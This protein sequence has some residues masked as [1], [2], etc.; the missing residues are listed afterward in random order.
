MQRKHSGK[1]GRR[2]RKRQKASIGRGCKH[3]GVCRFCI[4]GSEFETG[5]GCLLRRLRAST[6]SKGS[7]GAWGP[8]ET[9][10]G[11]R[12]T[13]NNAGGP[14]FHAANRE[15]ERDV[16]EDGKPKQI[17]KYWSNTG[18]FSRGPSSSLSSSTSWGGQRIRAGD[19][20]RFV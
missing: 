17:M 1:L 20:S 5:V 13:Q 3:C 4:C 18:Y 7:L 10:K 11:S 2:T 19:N 14:I 15:L 16:T 12:T 8:R 6:A 9:K